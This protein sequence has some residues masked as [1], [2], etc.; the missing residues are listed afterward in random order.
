VT[1]AADGF[2][3]KPFDADALGKLLEGQPAQGA[4]RSAAS[5][6]DFQEPVVSAETLAQLRGMMP[7]AAVRA[8][9]AALVADLAQRIEALEAAFAQGDAAEVRRIGHAIKG[10]CNMAGALQ[11]ARLGA[12][13]EEVPLGPGGAGGSSSSP[14]RGN[15][16]NDSRSLL[17]DLHAAARNLERMLEAELQA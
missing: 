15:Q 14:R 12:L 13:L 16:L 8:I 7:E 1:A 3:L 11:A 9:Y 17:G 6:P 5:L 2:L 4:A 10:G